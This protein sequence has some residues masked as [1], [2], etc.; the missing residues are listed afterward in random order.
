M[1]YDLASE[2][3]MSF[4]E[5]P[6]GRADGGHPQFNMG[7]DETE[8][9]ITGFASHSAFISLATTNTEHK[10][11]SGTKKGVFGL[12]CPLIVCSYGEVK[13][14]TC[15]LTSTGKSR[16]Q[17]TPR[18]LLPCFL[19]LGL[20]SGHSHHSCQGNGTTHSGVAQPILI[21]NPNNSC[22]NVSTGQPDLDNSPAGDLLPGGSRV[23]AS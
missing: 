13:E 16:E 1:F 5:Y 7:R 21:N 20:L 17:R 6:V 22:P 3:A 14:G 8:V 11:G 9:R 23:A 15:S 2:A 19:L 10:N 4:S 12:Q 18:F